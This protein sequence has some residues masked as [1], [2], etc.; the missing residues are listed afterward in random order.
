[1]SPRGAE[2][3]SMGSRCR[4]RLDE[5]LLGERPL[6]SPQGPPVPSCSWGSAGSGW[7]NQGA[8]TRD[9]MSCHIWAD[10]C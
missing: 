3:L 7:W 1:M 6:L 4:R 10:T 5:G 8:G 9:R 2:S